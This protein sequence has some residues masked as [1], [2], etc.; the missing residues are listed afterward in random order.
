[1]IAADA[2]SDPSIRRVVRR[3]RLEIMLVRPQ[4]CEEVTICNSLRIFTPHLHS[5]SSLRIR[6]W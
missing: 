2:V 4:N 3:L 6:A 5:A 1:M